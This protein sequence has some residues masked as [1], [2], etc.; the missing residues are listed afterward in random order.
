MFNM[1]PRQEQAPAGARGWRAYAVGDVHG[2]LDLLEQLLAKIHRDLGRHPS[3]KTLLL[4]V[5]DLIDRGPNSAQVI[6]RLRTYSR[7]GV[8]T[9]FLLGNHEEVLLRI[10]KGDSELIAKWRMFGGS[11]TLQSYGVEP[12][13]LQG[14]AGEDALAVVREAIPAAHVQ[15]LETFGDSVRFG[16]FLFVHAGIRPGI[17]VEQQRQTDL[18][19]IREPFLFDET[20]H[21]FVV[22]H[23]HTITPRVD[24]RPNRIAIDTGAY[25]T[26][27]LSAIAIERSRT[28]FLD[29]RATASAEPALTD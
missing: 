18:R 14:L 19:W 8:R 27:V 6:E 20:D 28:W 7:D 4:F 11:E 23:G 24:V 1:S 17:E 16:D 21:G 2:R 5:G 12:A 3:R 13:S 26:G 22:V 29:T 25:R 10:L 15:F 9:A